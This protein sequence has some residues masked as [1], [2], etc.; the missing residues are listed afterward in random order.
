MRNAKD[1]GLAADNV[2]ID[3]DAIVQRRGRF[4]TSEPGVSGLLKKNKVQTIW[5]E[6]R[7]TRLTPERC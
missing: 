4:R 2:R 6:A 7:S 1:Y 3:A 5:G